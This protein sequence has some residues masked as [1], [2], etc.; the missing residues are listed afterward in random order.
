MHKLRHTLLTVAISLSSTAAWSNDM[1]ADTTQIRSYTLDE[2]TIV[3]NPKIESELFEMPASI[4]LLSEQTMQRYNITS[5]KDI[6][7]V[8]GNV[9]IPDYGSNLITS[10]YIRGI[11]SRINSPAVGV[12]V[13][14]MPF[15]DKSAYDMDF[16]D[17]AR[18]EVLRGPQG[19]LYGR[20]TMAGLINIYTHSPLHKQGTR[21]QLGGGNYASWNVSAL[22]SHKITDDLGISLGAKYEEYDGYYKNICTGKTSG[23]RYT[24]NGRMQ[25]DWRS[26]SRIKWS[27]MASFE[28]SYQD[29]YPYASYTTGEINYNSPSSYL[30]NLLNVGLQMEYRHDKFYLTSTTGYQYL[31]D[32]MRMDQ[33]FTPLSVFT[34]GQKQRLH[35]ITQEVALRG[36]GNEHWGWTAGLFGSYQDLHVDAPV[37]FLEDGIAYLIEN[38]TNAAMA[39]AKENNPKMPDINIDVTNNAL[40]IA[41]EYYTPSYSLAVFGQ[42]EAKR[43]FDSNFSATLGARV[44]YENMRLDHNTYT[45]APLEG[46][47]NIGMGPMQLPIPFSC[48]L[49]LDGN[50]QQESVEFLPKLELKYTL[51]KD[52]MAYASVARGYRSGGYNYQAFSNLIQAQMRGSMINS[53]GANAANTIREQFKGTPMEGMTDMIIGQINGIFGTM[54]P[55]T[56]D[57]NVEDAIAYKPEYSWNYEVGVRGNMWNKRINAELTMFY[58]DCRD[59]QL[60]AVSGY[61]RVTRNSGRTESF[62]LEASVGITPIDNLRFTASYGFTHATFK[63]YE[64]GNPNEPGYINYAGKYVPF[65]PMHSLSVSGAYTWEFA[66]E[67]ALTL[68]LLGSGY[69]DIYWTEDNRVKQPFYALLD[70]TL[71]YKWRWLEV[72]L[73][74]KNLTC[75]EYNTFYFETTNAQNMAQP[76]AFAQQGKPITFGANATF[77]F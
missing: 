48:D 3:S 11:G 63:E 16:L 18:I 56:D 76:N 72:G 31:D 22:T 25:I 30:R 59:Q 27:L 39:A 42:V 58:I 14:N 35:A 64:L 29:G 66:Q 53:V 8:A 43:I 49:G 55:P 20:N 1:Q 45:A 62:G 38:P 6:P 54:V 71:T 52:F 12:N 34:L 51:N 26:S 10:A 9:Y 75:T 41:G 61:G 13:N 67:H 60:S 2:V 57:I 23:D 46:F 50:L 70:A 68:A 73:W 24:A 44:E 28:H 15:L 32:D 21:I 47:A 5:V 65:A 4:T 77:T 19:T 74:G 36:Y 7:S 37:S 17:V 69:G 40:N 33:D